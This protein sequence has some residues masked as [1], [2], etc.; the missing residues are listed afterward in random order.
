MLFFFF[1][2]PMVP[3]AASHGGHDD[4]HDDDLDHQSRTVCVMD[5]SGHLGTTLVQ[6][7]LNMGYTVHA[8]V[9]NHGWYLVASLA[10]I[11][12]KY[13]NLKRLMCLIM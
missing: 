1:F 8:A 4:V 10:K 3:A 9:Q 12:V 11:H 7:L 6:R 2:L 5:A 13:C